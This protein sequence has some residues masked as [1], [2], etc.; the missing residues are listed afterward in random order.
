[1]SATA[2]TSFILIAAAEIGD[3]S[4]LVCMTLTARRR[5]IPILLGAIASF[6][7]LNSLPLKKEG[8][9]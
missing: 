1:M 9:L 7:F 5:A 3:N 4:Q 2:S 8:F 6:A